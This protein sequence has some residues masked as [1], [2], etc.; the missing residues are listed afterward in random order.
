[1]KLALCLGVLVSTCQA[2]IH[3]DLIH[4]MK[5]ECPEGFFYAGESILPDNSTQMSRDSLW[6]EGPS[7]PVYSCYK[8][9][10][11]AK[12][13][14]GASLECNNIE[15]VVAQLVS[16]ESRGEQDILASQLFWERI[17]HEV[18]ST[19]SSS[20]ALTSGIQLSTYN[21]TWFGADV[22]FDDSVLVLENDISEDGEVECLVMRWNM[23]SNH[24]DL[25]FEQIPCEQEHDLAL[26]EAHVY[27]QTWYVW[28]YSNW[29]QVLLFVAM[30]LLILSACCLFQALFFRTRVRSGQ[31][32]PGR[33]GAR[34]AAGQRNHQQQRQR[35]A[36][37]P[38]AYAT[39]QQPPAYVDMPLP[40]TTNNT[41]QDESFIHESPA[42][43]YIRK[44]REIMAQVTFFKA[45]QN[46]KP[47][48]PQ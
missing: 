35:R 21:W 8:F 16:V 48:L 39:T 24:V 25:R 19:L 7:S 23:S 37:L 14:A 10:K 26:C 34:S 40:A 2:Y 36:S 44:G 15:G 9:I 27:T 43:R 6:I 29:L 32:L 30:L 20:G 12:T 47:P 45:P 22:Q 28:F 1:M 11:G 13:F 3:S 38:P 17:P 5:R 46:E 42:E 4:D 18:R 31:P 41:H 33:G